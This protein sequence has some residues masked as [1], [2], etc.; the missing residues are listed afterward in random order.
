MMRRTIRHP[1]ELA[2][3]GLHT[4]APARVRLQPDGPGTGLRF[5][6]ADLGAGALIRAS[7]EHVVA[8]DRRTTLEADG[9]R[10]ETVEHLL[11]AL[12]AHQVDDLLVEL[13]GP[14]VPIL[15]G[16]FAPF[17]A[18]IDSAGLAEHDSPRPVHRVERPLELTVGAARYAV[19]PAE[20][21]GL[22]VTL[23]YAEPVIGTQSAGVERVAE[24][25]GAEVAAAR[26]YGFARE[27]AALQARGLG[28]GAVEGC[29]ILLDATGPRGTTLRWPNEF[30]RH[31]LGDLLG[32]LALLGGRLAF[33]VS[34]WRPSHL[35]NVACARLVAARGRLSEEG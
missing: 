24:R 21:L 4:G 1:V 30:A 33:R 29:G 27:L 2:G 34:A 19:T 3:H 8:T 32:D 31:K 9:V 25:F 20:E 6:R 13:H 16:S 23:E 22:E 15:D 17:W 10:V 11:A 28:A 7:L 18:A 12:A 14:E 5:W 26:T 35:G